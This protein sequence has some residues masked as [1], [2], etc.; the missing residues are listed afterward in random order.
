MSGFIADP[1]WPPHVDNTNVKITELTDFYY[2]KPLMNYQSTTGIHNGL[3]GLS[4]QEVVALVIQTLNDPNSTSP[5]T[6]LEIAKQMKDDGHNDPFCNNAYDNIVAPLDT[7]IYCPFDETKGYGTLYTGYN[8]RGI[9]DIIE[10]KKELFYEPYGNKRFEAYKAIG[11]RPGQIRNL[12]N[13]ED[14]DNLHNLFVEQVRELI[15][16]KHNLLHE[17]FSRFGIQLRNH[18]EFRTK[19]FPSLNINLL[20]IFLNGPNFGGKKYKNKKPKKTKKKKNK[21]KY[22]KN[23]SRKSK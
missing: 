4:V 16:I 2:K 12:L 14:D 9:P 15:D 17:V 22:S 3:N 11:M 1:D 7:I 8:N 5:D 23:K 6:M 21:K 18:V 13:T 10:P 20:N 19:H